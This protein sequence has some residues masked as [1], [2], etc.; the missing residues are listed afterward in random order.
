MN[1]MK[2]EIITI[3]PEDFVETPQAGLQTPHTFE[4]EEKAFTPDVAEKL[5]RTFNVDDRISFDFDGRFKGTGTV[6]GLALDHIVKSY[7]VLLDTPV[8]GQKAILVGNTLMESISD[9]Y[10]DPLCVVD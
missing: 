6:L 3:K 4:L 9:T 5:R 8:Q 1:S 7:I 10:F 2:E